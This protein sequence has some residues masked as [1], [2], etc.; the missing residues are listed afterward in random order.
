MAE[1]EPMG[2]HK[3]ECVDEEMDQ[4]ETVGGSR[5][6]SRRNLIKGGAIL[7]GTIWVAPV[8]DSITNKVAAQS[9]ANYCC[10]CW[11][12]PS[13]RGG[14]QGEADEHPPT[15]VLCAAYCQDLGYTN[16][17]WCGPSAIQLTY[18]SNA[19]SPGCYTGTASALTAATNCQTGTV[20]PF[21]E[22]GPVLGTHV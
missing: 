6:I 4:E 12:P 11:P 17:T 3:E 14:F 5:G 15:A 9:N 22:S 2:R 19:S 8:I 21:S 16:Y 10:S 18:S 7:G 1:R 13:A 20:N